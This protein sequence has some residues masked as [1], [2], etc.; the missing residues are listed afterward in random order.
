MDSFTRHAHCASL[1]GALV[2]SVALVIV[3]AVAGTPA[4]GRGAP[5]GDGNGG[6]E[7]DDIGSFQSPVSVAFR[8]DVPED[9]YVVEQRGTVQVIPNGGSAVEFLDIRDLTDESGEQGLLSIAFDPDYDTNHR[10][11]AYYNDEDNGDIVVS[12]FDA[13]DPQNADEE[14]RE[15]V[16]R[17][18]HRFASN[19]NGGTVT[20]GPDGHMYL[21]TGDGGVADDPGERAQK[22]SSLL[23]KLLRIDPTPGGGH[24]S[25]AGNP[26]RGKP[27]KDE[28]YAVGLR[29][30]FRFSFD[31]GSGRITIGDVGQD[32]FEE[33]DYE[34]SKSLRKA[35]FG[36]DRYEGFRRVRTDVAS[37]PKPKNHDKPIRA[38]GHGRDG[39]SCSVIGGFV[40][41]DPAIDSVQ[42]RYV[43][44]DNC[45]G[46]IWTLIPQLNKAA[47]DK[48]LGISVES[49]AGFGEDPDGQ[50]YVAS[51]D[52][53]VYRLEPTPP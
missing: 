6:V 23:G 17:I 24:T 22:K 4:S 39:F 52:G 37:T 29:N 25:P 43:Y 21:G 2:V 41:R 48:R 8:P 44:T 30:P 16:I 35:N 53:P 11:Y 38:Y 1:I 27:G 40:S 7:L 12:S 47:D 3:L 26:F 9:V 45:S 15:Q 20:F 19:H 5:V 32:R 10:V 31:S 51:L 14:S 28:I 33:I 42:G 34:T 46:V 18:R 13:T 50:L 49:P 36:W